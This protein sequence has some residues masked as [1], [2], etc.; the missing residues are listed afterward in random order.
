MHAREKQPP[1]AAVPRKDTQ[2]AQ[3]ESPEQDPVPAARRNGFVRDGV[4]VP[5]QKDGGGSG[6]GDLVGGQKAEEKA[7]ENV[8]EEGTEAERWLPKKKRGRNWVTRN[9]RNGGG[10][11]KSVGASGS[12][13]RAGDV[14]GDE[15]VEERRRRKRVRT[16]DSGDGKVEYVPTPWSAMLSAAR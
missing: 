6:A 1:V 8:E 9:V 7:E 14:E 12:E 16:E 13:A 2:E 10:D 3:P 11:S 5:E 4:E 15:E